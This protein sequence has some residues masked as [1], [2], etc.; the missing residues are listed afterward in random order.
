MSLE[1]STLHMSSIVKCSRQHKLASNCTG[2]AAPLWSVPIQ[3]N[4]FSWGQ[5]MRDQSFISNVGRQVE[6]VGRQLVG[7]KLIPQ[8]NKVLSPAR[9]D[10]RNEREDKLVKEARNN[11][12]ELVLLPRGMSKRQRNNSKWNSKIKCLE[13]AT[14]VVLHSNP[15]DSSTNPTNTFSIISGPHPSNTTTLYDIVKAALT[16]RD[17]KGKSKAVTDDN[18]RLFRQ[19]QWQWLQTFQPVMKETNEKTDDE[20]K[21]KSSQIQ[22]DK[23]S[24]CDVDEEI[25]NGFLL[26]LALY[27]PAPRPNWKDRTDDGEGLEDH[28]SSEQPPEHQQSGNLQTDVRPAKRYCIMSPS[29]TLGSMLTGSTLLEFPTFELITIQDFISKKAK[30]LIQVVDRL[31]KLPDRDSRVNHGVSRW[32]RGSTRGRGR[33]GRVVGRDDA[34]SRNGRHSN[35]SSSFDGRP[36][37]RGWSQKRTAD[38]AQLQETEAAEKHARIEESAEVDAGGQVTVTSGLVTYDSD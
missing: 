24:N 20:T 28:D 17:K 9:L 4:E 8:G 7:N 32:E 10:E 5:L 21:D 34:G 15:A 1:F 31:S 25:A 37:D 2:I 14:E 3:A 30:G 23:D 6:Q 11:Q 36:Q 33:G 12:I 29:S 35:G 19:T 22:D 27:T 38:D 13:W 16:S 18:E 26:L